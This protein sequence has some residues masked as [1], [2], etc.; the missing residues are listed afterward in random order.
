MLDLI[1][2]Q[3]EKIGIAKISLFLT[4][5]FLFSLIFLFSSLFKSVSLVSVDDNDIQPG[6]SNSLMDS[7]VQDSP[8]SLYQLKSFLESNDASYQFSNLI[9][10]ENFYK[11]QNIR[12][13]SRFGSFFSTRFHDYYLNITDFTIIDESQSIQIETF[14]FTPDQ[15][16]KANIALIY[17]ASEFFD[18]RERLSASI[19]LAKKRCELAISKS[20]NINDVFIDPNFDEEINL[21]EFNSAN[22]LIA[23][24][25]A[26]FYSKCLNYQLIEDSISPKLPLSVLND[27]NSS[28]SKLLISEIFDSKMNTLSITDNIV[29]IAE[30]IKPS[31]PER[32]RIF[33]KVLFFFLSTVLILLSMKVLYRI[34]DNFIS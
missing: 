18:Q 31:E 16:L 3:L 14:G 11:S 24:K 33:I 17:I 28:S 30:P 6:F 10:I 26:T 29:I 34:K 20:D 19:A 9:D 27:V 25:S 12:I 22:A 8:E 4:T 7:F 5:L 21:D 13:F 2:N 15:S 23:S 1:Q 32:K